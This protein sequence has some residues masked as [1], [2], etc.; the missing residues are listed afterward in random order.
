MYEDLMLDLVVDIDLDL[1]IICRVPTITLVAPATCPGTL[2][3]S[4]H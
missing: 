1:D 4:T 3:L 2:V